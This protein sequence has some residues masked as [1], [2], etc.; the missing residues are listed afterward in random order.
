M[1]TI[2]F[3]LF[4]VDTQSGELRRHGLRVKLQAQPFQVLV[5]LLERPGE[6]VTREELTKRLWPDNTFVDYER[7]LNKAI[8]RLRF[9]LRDQPDKPRFVETLPQRGYRFI[10][11]V[12][13]TSN[14]HHSNSAPTAVEELLP[15]LTLAL[16]PAPIPQPIPQS[17]TWK[18]E[19]LLP[20]FTSVPSP[21]PLPPSIP[22]KLK[23]K[24][25]S[26]MALAAVA[27]MASIFLFVL[28]DEKSYLSRTRLGTL[29]HRVSAGHRPMPQLALSERRLTANPD[30]APVTGGV[31]SPDGKYLAYS[32]PTGLYL[33]Q[34][35]GGETVP[36]P[37]PKG[38]DALPESWFPDSVHLVVSRVEGLK[39]PPSL[40]QISI[41]GGTP[42]KL[43][44]EGSSARVSPDGSKIVF[45]AGMWD[46]EE[47]WLLQVDENSA[48]KIA[49]NGKDYFGPLAWAPD[50]KRFA[51][52]RTRE[53]PGQRIDSKIEVYDVTNARS[54]AI[55]S[56]PR[57]LPDVA[58]I[59]PERLI[60]SLLETQP[61]QN[62][63]NLWSVQLDSRTGHPLGSPT[64]ITSDR[65]PTAGISVTSNGKR[66]VLLRRSHQF[67]IYLAEVEAHGR[68]LSTPRPLTLRRLT[69]DERQDF[70]TAW[71]PD[72]K[73]V[74]FFSD[75]DEPFHIYKQNI[76]QTQPELLVGGKDNVVLP[77]LTP[78]GLSVL[79]QVGA[80]PGEPS[81]TIRLMRVPLAGGPSQFVLE[82]RGII[83]VECA[84]LPS[85]LCIYGQVEP[86]Q[87]RF[88]TFDPVGGK[89]EKLLAAKLKTEQGPSTNWALSPDGKYLVRAKSSN[90]YEESGLRLFNLTNGKEQ[91]IPVS[92][93]PLIMGMDWAADSK[94]LWITGYLGRGAWGARSALLNVDLTGRATVVLEGLNLEL[95]AAIPS[96]DGHRLA[97]GRNTQSS[98]VSLLENF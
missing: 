45:L 75:R 89:G 15:S 31:I 9:A 18:L 4:E 1:S 86:G 88:F 55:F 71:T 67:D 98:N 63:F 5:L 24:L 53:S 74:L 52:V 41:M 97:I 78:D 27:V 22:P 84:R 85:T 30:D 73:A 62:V 32:D 10:A 38:F 93:L 57:L 25:K 80:K 96:P 69:L 7:G 35:D 48:R 16:G 3:G 51:Y 33:R 54:E 11:P 23:W 36:V 14:G 37:L 6:V 83:N 66:M 34:V 46:N 29:L 20:A 44:N 12:E 39:M 17:G 72:S 81:D 28:A 90:P 77:R 91:D 87:Q 92:S 95:W 42:R 2:R 43:A 68:R 59:N 65:T 60:Y 56:E 82:D 47:I 13:V 49:A 94:S 26:A 8:N 76:D 19:E 58:W 40:W 79:Y 64:R 50:G 21:T 61:S 70:P